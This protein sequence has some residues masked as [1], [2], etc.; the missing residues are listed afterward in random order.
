MADTVPC[1]WVTV[2]ETATTRTLLYLHG[3]GYVIGSPIDYR[4]ML[5]DVARA[6][7][8]RVLAV[9]YRLAP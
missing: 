6:A 2:S 4:G 1:E 7:D 9:D 8:A 5:P 3:G